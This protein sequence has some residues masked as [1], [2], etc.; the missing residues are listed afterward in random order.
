MD[1]A[2]ILSCY[3]ASYSEAREKFLRACEARELPVESHLNP[4]AKGILGED[5]T[6]DVAWIGA[7][8]AP[9]VLLVMSGTHGVEGYCGS[10]QQI[11]LLE[12]SVF[13]DLPPDLSVLMVHAMNPYGFSHDR[14]VNENNIDLNRN[15]ID[16]SAPDRPNSGYSQIHEWIL[17]TDWNGPARE[18][19]DASI[20]QYIEQHGL[21]AFQAAVSSGQYDFPDGLF[22]G[23]DAPSWANTMFRDVISN[24][25]G[26]AQSIGAIDFHTGLGPF[27]YGE[28]IAIGAEKQKSRARQ[29]YGEQVTDPEAGTSTSADLDGMVAHGLV[30]T[31]TNAEI[32]FITIEF[33]TYDINEVLTALRGDNW[34]YRHGPA[35]IE[36]YLAVN[37]KRDIRRAFYP[38]TDEWKQAVWSLSKEVVGLAIQGILAD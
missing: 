7:L 33:G 17:P 9:K 28:L 2:T 5:L 36:S 8:D 26:N 23:G 12:S 13:D 6:S 4:H 3:S 31:L 21:K 32:A 18:Q 1:D 15:F 22:Y 11:A 29:W 30:E 10:A 20:A 25:L 38:E 24:R 27:G 34:L 35:D 37:I 14:R 19:A 16:F